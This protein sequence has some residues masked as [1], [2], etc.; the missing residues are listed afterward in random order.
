MSWPTKFGNLFT[1]PN[2]IDRF[3]F[4]VQYVLIWLML[5]WQLASAGR[6]AVATDSWRRL[7]DTYFI[8]YFQND[9]AR[10]AQ[11]ILN[12]LQT[13]YHRLSQEIHVQIADSISVFVT[14]S[15][16]VYEQLAGK[17]IPRWS[18]GLASPGRNAIILKSP[19]WMPPETDHAAI[20]VHELTHLLLDRATNGQPLP[21]WLNEGL[22]IY[23]SGEKEFTATTLV[24]KAL[25]TNS[26]IPLDEID[27]VL[28]FHRSKAQLA[29]QESHLAV[30][31]LIRNYGHDAIKNILYN[32]SIGL[33]ADQAF[34]QALQVD[35]WDFEDEWLA[36]VKHRF[37][38][39]FL[40]ELDSYLWLII[41]L[42]FVIGFIV[43]RRRNRRLMESWQEEEELAEPWSNTDSNTP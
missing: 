1:W 41:L 26:M 27:K 34:L 9:D 10:N 40:L 36:D 5:L 14:P 25:A 13:A 31:Y 7:N 18:D 28:A 11:H 24:S 19:R 38:W 3:D 4:M 20:A 29:Y 15:Q 32:I 8:V 2:K 30:E 21:R 39:H 43:I 35:T 12:S 42:L 16:K 33:D 17:Q 6:D 37:R 22:A 23:Y